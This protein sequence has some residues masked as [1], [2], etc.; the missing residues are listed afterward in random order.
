MAN[1]RATFKQAGLTRAAKGLAAAGLEVERV[2]IDREG[3]IV[4]I[5][6]GVTS[7]S[8]ANPCDVLLKR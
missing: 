5:P 7:A 3:K 8:G 1:A 2:E 4:I 6:R